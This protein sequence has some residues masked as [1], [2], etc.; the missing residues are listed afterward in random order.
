MPRNIIEFLQKTVAAP[1]LIPYFMN[2][3]IK[4]SRPTRNPQSSA[5]NGNFPTA[6]PA[7]SGR[8]SR[9]GNPFSSGPE[10]KHRFGLSLGVKIDGIGDTTSP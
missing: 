6:D 7:V 2:Y 5:T 3:G 10:A 4:A 1:H 8:A 9:F